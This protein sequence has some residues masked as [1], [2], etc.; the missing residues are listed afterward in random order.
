MIRTL[1]NIFTR[2][3]AAR[4]LGVAIATIREVKGAFNCLLV[5]FYNRRAQFVSATAF[6]A[7]AAALRTAGAT[8]LPGAV[9]PL[10]N[11]IYTVQGS[12]GDY[13]TIDFALDACNCPDSAYRQ[14]RCKHVIKVG[15]YL[16]SQKLLKRQQQR[17]CVAAR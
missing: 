11:D 5:V 13:Y 15:G 17:V 3:A 8:K 4:I 7:D 12:R 10:G 6:E 16:E 1:Q 14:T 9:T 2:T